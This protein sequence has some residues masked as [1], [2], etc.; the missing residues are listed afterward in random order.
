MKDF[1]SATQH[2]PGFEVQKWKDVDEAA[3]EWKAEGG[4]R[5]HRGENTIKMEHKGRIKSTSEVK[6]A[7]GKEARKEQRESEP[8]WGWM[9][10]LCGACVSRVPGGGA[11]VWRCMGG[12]RI[13]SAVAQEEEEE[14]DGA[15]QGL[16]LIHLALSPFFYLLRLKLPQIPLTRNP[17]RAAS[18][19]K[20]SWH[21][22]PLGAHAWALFRRRNG[23]WKN[24]TEPTEGQPLLS[25][26][27]I[28]G[29]ALL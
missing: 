24:C 2:F 5:M 26:G 9:W 19:P 27:K 16:S 3:Q 21:N 11:P 14:E 22:S 25:P 4:R 17:L 10:W 23:H 1:I 13:R 28:T 6:Q 29:S 20:G 18:H 8:L 7:R 15:K 12:G